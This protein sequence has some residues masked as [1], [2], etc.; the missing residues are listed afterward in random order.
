LPRGDRI[1]LFVLGGALLAWAFSYGDKEVPTTAAHAAPSQ[2]EAST[3]DQDYQTFASALETFRRTEVED[4]AELRA[5]AARLALVH[6]R[7]DAPRVT[8]YYVGLTPAERRRGLDGYEEFLDIWSRVGEHGTRGWS[9]ALP[10]L[11][12]ELRDLAA[13]GLPLGDFV[14]AGRALSL[15]AEIEVQW[16]EFLDDDDPRRPELLS[17]AE[18]HVREALAVFERAGMWTPR[19]EPLINLGRLELLQGFVQRGQE[20]FERCLELAETTH[21]D[22]YRELAL[23]HLIQLARASADPAR[24]RRLLSEL[25]T[26][27]DPT[28]CWAL[29]RH[30]ALLL[31][32]EDHAHN[33]TEFL[34]AHRPGTEDGRDDWRIVLA[35]ARLRNGEWDEARR[36]LDARRQIAGDEDTL[37][38]RAALDL[39]AGRSAAVLSALAPAET[40][41]NLSAHGRQ[42]AA[43][44]VGEAHLIE[45]RPA[46]ALD[47]MRQARTIAES[48]E[49]RLEAELHLSA[50][51]ASVLGERLGLHAI[52]LEARALLE[53]GRPLEAALVVERAHSQR[54]RNGAGPAGTPREELTTSDLLAWAARYEHGLVTWV[55]GADSAVAVHVDAQ[56]QVGGQ[57]VEVTRKAL[58]RGVRRVRS[59]LIAADELRAPKLSGELLEHLLPPS[60]ERALLEGGTA[61]ERLLCLVHGPLERLPLEALELEGRSLDERA[62]LL[63]LPEL[64]AQRP[65]ATPAAPLEWTL[66]G[67]PLTEDGRPRLPLALEELEEIEILSSAT[68]LTAGADFDRTALV[69]AI[70]S[71]RAL[72]VATHLTEGAGC[73][74]V[75]FADVGLELSGG[76]SLCA[77]EIASL[78]THA[79]LVV[80]AACESAGGRTVDGRGQQGVAR[81]FL[82]AGARDLLVTLWPIRDD[83]ARHFTPEFHAALRGG[84]SPSRAAREAR[85]ALAK[86]GV[87]TADWA[88]FR[89]L[90]RD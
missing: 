61:D 28:D 86:S 22:G 7:H 46:A 43:V 74:T 72:H 14:P 76:G 33:A 40:R 63:V 13:R 52:V 79:P 64:P 71:N 57:V 10:D 4:P 38:L 19:L 75:R 29:A 20:R 15:L 69:A 48:W 42:E 68:S 66:M 81:A 36:L 82:E 31:I 73:P 37:L 2:N 12:A 26:F 18:R 25:A 5:A 50:T 80:L 30:H 32:A 41:A 78:E 9:E 60:L 11:R 23:L 6:G 90:G 51:S 59:A 35:M 83:V 8:D 54:W 39:R 62:T 53:L 87:A 70:G 21:Q 3:Y 84:A 16:L 27:R 55:C 44:L 58:E 56:G 67:S 89:I 45:G 24:E 34:I 65:G 88:A 85:R 1:L 17:E 49:S 47:F 77:S